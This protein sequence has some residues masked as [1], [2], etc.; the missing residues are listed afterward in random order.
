[1]LPHYR[2]PK[3]EEIETCS[4]YLDREIGLVCPEII[5]PMGYYATSYILKKY[6]HPELLNREDTE[7]RYGKLLRLREQNIYP[8]MHPTALVFDA[9][10][11][12]KMK[13]DYGKLKVLL[14]PCKWYPV[15]PMKRFYENGI[16]DRKW[17]QLYCRGDWESCIRYRME[18]SGEAH[19]DWMLP[20]G[21]LDTALKNR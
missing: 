10:D 11:K 19:P 5:S 9:T 1:M 14:Y 20:D 8:L 18:E 4:E 6:N 13:K 3:K 15:C 7:R 17:V 2:K 21:S 16:L 12:E